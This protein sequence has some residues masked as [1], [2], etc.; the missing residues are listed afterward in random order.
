MNEA[1][2][3]LGEVILLLNGNKLIDQIYVGCR[4]VSGLQ[5]NKKLELF[6]MWHG[7]HQLVLPRTM[8]VIGIVHR[9]F[10]FY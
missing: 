2:A 8:Q 9:V 7:C 3:A 4:W 6:S 10:I 1:S 5:L